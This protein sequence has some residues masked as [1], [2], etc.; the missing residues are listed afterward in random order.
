ML[1][2]GASLSGRELVIVILKGDTRVSQ[3]GIL[4]LSDLAQ[5]ATLEKASRSHAK[6]HCTEHDLLFKGVLRTHTARVKL[7]S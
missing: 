7:V 5:L 1:Y 6:E 4:N 3:L 2:L